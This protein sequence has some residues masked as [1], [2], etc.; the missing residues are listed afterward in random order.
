M[1]IFGKVE[2]FLRVLPWRAECETCIEEEKE[3]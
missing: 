2:R 3:E 1:L